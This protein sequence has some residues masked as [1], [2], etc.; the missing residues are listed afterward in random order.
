[1]RKLV[2]TAVFMLA[3][4]VGSAG[5]QSLGIGAGS[6]GSQNYAL[7]A[8]IGK[9][10]SEKA[11]LDVRV[12]SFGGSGGSMPLIDAGRL[13][14]QAIAAPSVYS[15]VLGEEPFVGRAMENLRVLGVVGPSSY[16]IF[17][18]KDS[19]YRTVA[20]LKGKSITYGF[21]NQP[22]LTAQVDGILANSGLSIDDLKPVM[23][24]SVTRG[25]DDF[26][27]GNADAA[28]MSLNS[29]KTQEADA[30]VGVR[31]LALKHGRDGEEAM[32][33]H[34]R[35]AYVQTIEPS[36]K[37][38]G[39]DGPTPMMSYDYII[40]AGAHV[41]D[42]TIHTIV[43]AIGDN[44]DDFRTIHKTAAGFSRDTFY[45]PMDGLIYHPGALRYFS[46]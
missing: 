7:N 35:G 40:I 10:L 42:E 5:A 43:K 34:V 32:R 18:R 27:A 28:F 38:F 9:F 20:D 8:A 30:A 24:P 14:L 36:D 41:D 31:W 29:G 44:A 6:Q 13:D 16:G 21:T 12:Q 23:A 3:M 45:K 39:I 2:K 26:I 33:K 11:G 46:E 25:I 22:S 4:S 17:V 37:V 1:M 19:P 15:A